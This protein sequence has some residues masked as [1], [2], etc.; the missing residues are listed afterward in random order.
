QPRWQEFWLYIGDLPDTMTFSWEKARLLWGDLRLYSETLWATD[1]TQL[2]AGEIR[3]LLGSQAYRETLG[4][5]TKGTSILQHP[6][7]GVDRVDLPPLR[8]GY[9]QDLLVSYGMNP[10]IQDKSDG[11]GFK[12]YARDHALGRR[13]VLLDDF[14]NPAHTPQDRGWR[15]KRIPMTPHSRHVL[16]FT[17]EVNP[18]PAGDATSDHALWCEARF[19]PRGVE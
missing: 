14:L 5:G 18:G 7:F 3:R 11:V 15:T 4:I 16:T 8:M 6:G 2:L 1:L 17:F 9:N 19:V 10:A 13:Y 12:L